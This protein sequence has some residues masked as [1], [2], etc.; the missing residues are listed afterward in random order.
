M[1]WQQRRGQYLWILAVFLFISS[2]RFESFSLRRVL[3]FL[4]TFVYLS[5]SHTL[6]LTIDDDVDDERDLEVFFFFTTSSTRSF[7]VDWGGLLGKKKNEGE[8]CTSNKMSNKTL[9]IV[10]RRWR[11]KRSFLWSRNWNQFENFNN[12]WNFVPTLFFLYIRIVLMVKVFCTLRWMVLV[13]IW[14]DTMRL[15]LVMFLNCCCRAWI[16]NYGNEMVRMRS[17]GS[18]EASET[19]HG[20]EVITSRFA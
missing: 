7:T 1:L 3:F 20:I 16:I 5:T 14:V 8:F 12:H 17:A 13:A 2:S 6:L 11:R 18:R 9:L 19:R 10:G 15:F 4:L